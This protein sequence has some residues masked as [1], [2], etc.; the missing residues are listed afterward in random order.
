MKKVIL[1]SFLFASLFADDVYLLKY[2]HTK[3]KCE[4]TKNGKTIPFFDKQFKMKKPN[5]PYTCFSIQK[6]QYNDCKVIDKKNVTAM[7]YGYGSYDSTN[8][9]ISFKNPSKSVDSF[10]KVQCTKNKAYKYT[11]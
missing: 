3:Q 9:I 10:V 5:N 11:K 2:D 4:L 6:E 1:I 7:Y 8:A